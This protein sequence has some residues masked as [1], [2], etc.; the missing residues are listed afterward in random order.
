[1]PH[2]IVS[3]VIPIHN[4]AQ[5]IPELIA[6]IHTALSQTKVPFEVIAVDDKSTD[7]TAH[8][9]KTVSQEYPLQIITKQKHEKQGKAYSLL[10][11]FQN[12]TGEVIA[13]IDADLSYPPEALPPMLKKIMTGEADLVVANREKKE[14]TFIRNV[15]GSVF[16]KIFSEILH[17]V[18]L[19][20]QSGLKAFR[21]EIIERITLHPTPWTFDIELLVKAQHAGYELDSVPITFRKRQKGPSKMR[22]PQAS[23]EIGKA[24]VDLKL[25]G[26]SPIPF[27]PEVIEKEGRGFHF[28]GKKFIPHSHLEVHDTALYRLATKQRLFLIT[29]AIVTIWALVV[30]WHAALIGIIAVLTILY[31]ADLLFN[32]FLI[33]SSFSKPPELVVTDEEMAAMNNADWPSYT[34]FCPLYKEPEVIPQFVSAMSELDYPKDKLQIMLLL[35]EDDVATIEKARSFDLPSYFEVVVV[36]HSLPKTKPKASNYGLLKATGEF[37]VIYDAE[38]VPDP[39]QLKKAVIAFNKVDPKIVCIQAKLN[40]YNPHQNLLT[41]AFTAEYSLW[42]DLVLTGLQATNTPIPLGGTSNHFRTNKLRELNGWDAFNVTEDC[43]LGIRLAKR[44]YNTA[45]LDSTTLEEANSSLMNW[46]G[47]RSRWIKGYMQTY[48]VHMR[49]PIQFVKKWNDPHVLTFQLVVGGKILSMF[50]N[51]IM[52]TIT[53]SYFILRPFVGEFIESLYPTPVLYMGVISFVFGNFL[54]L[55]YY[56]I[57]CAKREHYDLVKYAYLVPFYWLAMSVAA[58]IALREL[59]L[60]PHHWS[61]TKHGL[62]INSQKAMKQA[63]EKVG[64]KLVHTSF[65]E[66]R[67]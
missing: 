54:Y 58:W 39:D 16:Q 7:T 43:D 32:F 30:N 57:G 37:S 34:I 8:V 18:T 65:T 28:K 2:P 3:V 33:Y 22:V 41:R 15:F 47:Q 44:G 35:E 66:A 9:L 21:S 40:F 48:L 19:D 17:G 64:R 67:V 45:V 11:G 53:L 31:F 29:L 38:D 63:Q 62:H 51:P 23:W 13:M 36:P 26:P 24:A 27:L 42:F 61:K 55:Y 49:D 50:I 25:R 14:A 59:I 5:N 12:A 20:A 6:R 56:M 1:M 60:R 4:E 10:L 52:W 46:F